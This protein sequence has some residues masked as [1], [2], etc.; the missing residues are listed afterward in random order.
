MKGTPTPKKQ[1]AQTVLELFVQTVSSF[2]FKY[3]EIARKS[4]RKLSVQTVFWLGVFWGGLP[5]LLIHSCTHVWKR[6]EYCFESTVS[7]KRTH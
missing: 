1:F 4:L 6:A 5:D 2:F 3:G 7:E